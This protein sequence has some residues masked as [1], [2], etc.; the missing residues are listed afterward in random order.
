MSLFEV[1]GLPADEVEKLVAGVHS[2]PFRILGPHRI[3]E[4][5]AVRVFRPDAQQVE[6]ALSRKGDQRFVAERIHSAGFFQACLPGTR[7]NVAYHLHLTGPDGSTTTVNDP[8]SY[9]TIMGDV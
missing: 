9:G 1:T 7:G 8:Y 2:D 6:I 3:G 4:D 5:L